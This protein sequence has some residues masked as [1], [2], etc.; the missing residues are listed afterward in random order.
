MRNIIYTALW[1]I[2]IVYIHLANLQV[3]YD[4]A[5]DSFLNDV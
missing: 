4:G 1:N 2:L 3:C 5:Y